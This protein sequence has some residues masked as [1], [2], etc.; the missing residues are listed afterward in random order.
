MV[1]ITMYSEI[2]KL[3]ALGYKKQRA[4][5]QL[6]VDT[7]T[8]RKYWNMTEDDY[9]S[10]LIETKERSKIMDPYHDYVLDKLK[11]YPEI[12]SAIIYDNLRE[13]FIDFSP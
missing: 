9:V 12:S 13:D 1:G 5:R 10:Y 8:V 3:K 11:T 7:K 4:A 6:K 2:Q